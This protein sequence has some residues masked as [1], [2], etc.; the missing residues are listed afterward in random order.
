MDILIF[1][2]F[3]IFFSFVFANVQSAN[4]SKLFFTGCQADFRAVQCHFHILWQGRWNF[5]R[6]NQTMAVHIFPHTVLH[7]FLQLRRQ[8]NSTA[9]SSNDTKNLLLCHSVQYLC[10]M[11]VSTTVVTLWPHFSSLSCLYDIDIWLLLHSIKHKL[12]QLQLSIG[13]AT[14]ELLKYH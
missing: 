6:N 5:I 14:S 13:F 1:F 2:I 4:K 9:P 10:I 12:L 11:S 8:R 7:L 3:W